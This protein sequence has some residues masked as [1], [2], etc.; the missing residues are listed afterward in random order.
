[1]CVCVCVCVCVVEEGWGRH[2]CAELESIPTPA[3]GELSPS[4]F[5]MVTAIP[6]LYFF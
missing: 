2:N 5:L 6:L 4:A 1:V 3:Q